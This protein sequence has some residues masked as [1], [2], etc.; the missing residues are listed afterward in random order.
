MEKVFV[1]DFTEMPLSDFSRPGFRR[2]FECYF[3]EL[4]VS[5]DDWDAV[6]REMA[7]SGA[8]AL[9]LSSHDGRVAAFLL[10][11]VLPFSSSFFEGNAAF[12]QEFWV[13]PSLR[14][15]GLGRR[16]LHSAEKQFTAQGLSLVLLTSDT[17]E[18]FYLRCGYRRATGIRAKNDCPV[19]MRC[20]PG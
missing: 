12:I 3:A 14:G 15:Q 19:F 1:S 8:Q 13:E 6:Y 2:A 5:V 7:A 16:L 11:A 17:A 10:Y 4:E 20:L 18:G 9:I